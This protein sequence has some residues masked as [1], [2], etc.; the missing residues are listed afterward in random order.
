M[1]KAS[2][3]IIGIKVKEIK[4]ETM[5]ITI[6]RGNMFV[7]KTTTVTTPSI[8]FTMVTEMIKVG[9]M[10]HLKLRRLLLVMVEVVWRELRICCGI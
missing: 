6:E 8:G 5:V 9:L 4:V 1:P 10:F 7:M 3:R 2:I